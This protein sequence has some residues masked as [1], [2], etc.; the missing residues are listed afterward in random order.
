[1]ESMCLLLL[2]TFYLVLEPECVLVC[3]NDD[4]CYYCNNY[5]IGRRI[6]ELELYISLA[7]V[8]R[9]FRLAFP[10]QSPMKAHFGGVGIEVERSLNLLFKDL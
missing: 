8:M 4:K 2:L 1:M 10:E 9:N 3:H 5:I 7:N 6:D